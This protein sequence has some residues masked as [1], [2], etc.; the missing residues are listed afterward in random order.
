L[1]RPPNLIEVDQAIS[2]DLTRP[3]PVPRCCNFKIRF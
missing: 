2:S 1:T 3:A